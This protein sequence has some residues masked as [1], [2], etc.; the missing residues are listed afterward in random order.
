[1][2]FGR[3]RAFPGLLADAGVGNLHIMLRPIEDL[4]T[5]IADSSLVSLLAQRLTNPLTRE[6]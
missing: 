3:K 1:V 2:A 4:L 6:V 5:S